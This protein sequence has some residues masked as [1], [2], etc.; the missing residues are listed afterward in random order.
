MKYSEMWT[1]NR[2][3]NKMEE[4]SAEGKMNKLN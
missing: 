2:V 3:I 1:L 4:D